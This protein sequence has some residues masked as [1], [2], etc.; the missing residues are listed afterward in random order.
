MGWTVILCDEFEK[1]LASIDP[2]LRD[3]LLA[4]LQHLEIF[5]PKLG[6]PKVDTVKNSKFTNMKELRFL[7]KRNP[8]RY[9]FA[10]DIHRNAVVLVG[11][12]KS[13]DKRFYERMI[14]IADSRF[15]KYIRQQNKKQL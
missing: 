13:N 1:E 9:F 10:F 5:G 12:N 15:E 6:R 3:E 7:Y 14:I 2:D 4:Q 11:G 8:Y